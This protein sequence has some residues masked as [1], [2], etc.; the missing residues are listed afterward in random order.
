MG[1]RKN[2]KLQTGFKWGGIHPFFYH[3]F[4]SSFTPSDLSN[5]TIVDIGCGKGLNGFLIRTTRDLSGSKMIGIDINENYLNFCKVHNIYDKLYKRKV[6][7]IPIRDKSVDFL[8]CTEVIEHMTKKQGNELLN[9]V[10]RVTRGRALITTPNV[11]FQTHPGEDEDSHK[12]LWTSNDF[13]KRGY[14]SYGIGLR[15]TILPSDKLIKIKQ[16]LYYLITP[17]SYF[18]PSISGLLIN[19]KDY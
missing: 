6:P 1:N 14:K 2:T 5:K 19:V 4:L 10:D 16:A 11:F 12:S 15:T 8:L 9:E 13:R 17:I 18:F 3:S 7:K